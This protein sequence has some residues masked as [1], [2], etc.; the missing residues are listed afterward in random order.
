MG[1][2][3]GIKSMTPLFSLTN[4]LGGFE[5]KLNFFVGSWAS[6]SHSWTETQVSGRVGPH[7]Q[8]CRRKTDRGW[9]RY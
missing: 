6:L 9:A 7:P 2:L 1:L 3:E 5:A 8:S 4:E